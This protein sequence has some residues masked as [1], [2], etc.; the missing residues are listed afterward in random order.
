MALKVRENDSL[1]IKYDNYE[2]E[3]H[4]LSKELTRLH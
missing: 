3:I 4:S 1:I 2:L